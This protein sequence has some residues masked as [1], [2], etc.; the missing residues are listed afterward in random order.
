M[1]LSWTLEVNEMNSAR[2]EMQG[3]GASGR[4]RSN[5]RGGPNGSAATAV[6]RILEW[7]ILYRS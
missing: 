4:L 3:F 7:N 1:E 5:R 2:A 6:T